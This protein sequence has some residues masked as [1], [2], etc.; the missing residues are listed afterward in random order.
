MEGR[1]DYVAVEKQQQKMVGAVSVDKGLSSRSDG[2]SMKT[3]RC[4]E[5]S[6]EE[7]LADIST[8]DLLLYSKKYLNTLPSTCKT[9]FKVQQQKHVTKLKVC[10][11][12]MGN[13]VHLKLEGK[14]FLLWILETNAYR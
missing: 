14:L 3:P 5:A 6:W 10:Q 13:C 12:W 7:Y 1:Y 8:A 4:S 2:M 9:T 11:C